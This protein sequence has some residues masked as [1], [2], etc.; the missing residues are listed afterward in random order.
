MSRRYE[1]DDGID[2]PADTAWDE[3]LREDAA[4][5]TQ[6]TAPTCKR[7]GDAGFMLTDKQR[8]ELHARLLALLSGSIEWPHLLS[9]A[10]N[11]AARLVAADQGLC[12]NCTAYIKGPAT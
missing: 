3:V 4:R 6:A 12:V 8:L 5:R 7:C 11:L 2:G 9:I 10:H 1:D